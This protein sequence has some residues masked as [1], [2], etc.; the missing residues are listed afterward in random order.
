MATKFSAA[1]VTK[2]VNNKF[3]KEFVTTILCDSMYD[4]PWFRV[5]LDSDNA[6]VKS[7]MDNEQNKCREDVWADILMNNGT[8]NIEDIEDEKTYTIGL[9]NL[10]N[11]L[12]KLMIH[13]PRNYASIM[14][15]SYDFYDVDMLM[16][17]AVFGEVIYG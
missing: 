9:N 10:K 16:Q 7:A 14:D 1:S 12:V 13:Y 2:F 5:R 11:G 4:S 3:D 15:E 17:Y 8:I 6:I